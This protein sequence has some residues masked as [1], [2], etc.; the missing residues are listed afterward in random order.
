MYFW[1][2]SWNSLT[3]IHLPLGLKV[4]ATTA[5]MEYFQLYLQTFNTGGNRNS[6]TSYNQKEDVWR[7][8]QVGVKGHSFQ[9]SLELTSPLLLSSGAGITDAYHIYPGSTPDSPYIT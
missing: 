9:A 2:L 8:R 5:W 6:P 1:S 4:C 3:E 7:L